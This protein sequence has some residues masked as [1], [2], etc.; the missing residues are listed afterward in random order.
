MLITGASVHPRR[1]ETRRPSCGRLRDQQ[2]P[3]VAARREARSAEQWPAFPLRQGI[4]PAVA[5]LAQT[6]EAIQATDS[7][8][9]CDQG[10]LNRALE[11]ANALYLT[12]ERHGYRVE[13]VSWQE[14]SDRAEPIT[15]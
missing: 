5:L 11:V 13:L 4:P 6:S 14:A 12:F 10:N 9:L 1:R 15:V 2:Q 3:E 8:C 7:R